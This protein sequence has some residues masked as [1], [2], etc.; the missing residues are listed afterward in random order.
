MPQASKRYTHFLFAGLCTALML[1]SCTTVAFAQF[2][3]KP[4]VP[5]NMLTSP[6]FKPPAG[7][8][9]A[10]VEFDDLGCP[11]CAAWNPV[12]MQAAAKYHVAWVRH[13]FLIS[14]HVWSRTAAVNA[15]WFDEK[16]AKLGA[17]YR[18]AIFADQPNIA[19]EQELS[20][21][22]ARYAQ[23]HGLAMPFLVDPQGKL[24]DKVLADC[25][26]GASLGVHETPTVWVVTTG[27]HDPGYSFVRVNDIRMLYDYLDQAISATKPE[28]ARGKNS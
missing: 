20:D 12:L 2:P 23:Q 8:R 11:M 14:Y 19:T 5:A 24:L 13:D 9:V 3:E 28:S 22:T 10:I 18:N 27:S 16:S 1:A 25:H 4:Q 17:D 26:L 7:S 15:R 21:C 6:A